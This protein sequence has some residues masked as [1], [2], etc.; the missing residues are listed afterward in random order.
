MDD[1]SMSLLDAL[2]RLKVERTFVGHIVAAYPDDVRYK[3]LV[4]AIDT[5]TK[6]INDVCCSLLGVSYMQILSEKENSRE[7]IHWKK[8]KK[9]RQSLTMQSG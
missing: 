3:S 5:V 2:E 4:N 8:V 1:S 6:T 7:S 9:S